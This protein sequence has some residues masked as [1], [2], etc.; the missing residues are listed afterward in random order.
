VVVKPSMVDSEDTY[1]RMLSTWQPVR[2][3]VASAPTSCGVTADCDVYHG[4][5]LTLPLYI[6]TLVTLLPVMC[7]CGD[8]DSVLTRV[9]LTDQCWLRCAEACRL[10]H[11]QQ[12]NC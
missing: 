1:A 5:S 6:Y 10:S 11:A 8:D 3:A 7:G 2:S 4:R 9:E 12:T